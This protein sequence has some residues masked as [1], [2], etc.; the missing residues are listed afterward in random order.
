M[1]IAAVCANPWSA[2]GR[3]L[4]R[5]E[6]LRTLRGAVNIPVVDVKEGEA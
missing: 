1:N 6:L 5:E 4:N 2:Y 3:H